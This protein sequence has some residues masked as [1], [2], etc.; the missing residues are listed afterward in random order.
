MQSSAQD[1]FQ[2]YLDGNKLYSNLIDYLQDIVQSKLELK[3]NE[4]KRIKI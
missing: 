4:R 1:T 2:K 3:T